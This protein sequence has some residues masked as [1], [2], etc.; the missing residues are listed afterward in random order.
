MTL[1]AVVVDDEPLARARLR[2]LLAQE[3]DLEVVGE[4]GNGADAVD[5]IGEQQPDVVFLDLHMPQSGG[6]EVAR[7]LRAEDVPAIVFVTAHDQ[8]AVEAFEVQA[9]DY[10]LKPVTRARLQEAVRR[11]RQRLRAPVRPRSGLA[12]AAA[13]PGEPPPPWLNRFAVKQG[14]QTLFVKAQDVDYIEAAANYVVLCTR[15]GNHILR[16]TL[17]NLEGSLSPASFLRVSRSVIVNLERVSAIRAVAPGEW[18]MV[19]AGGREFPMTRGW[20]EV[21]ERLQYSASP[22]TV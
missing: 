6:L 20:K 18:Q 3:P 17:R 14:N 2:R 11:V 12:P 9:T 7:A 16:E 5:C 8:H 10:L 13:A 1:R 21:Q 4:C 19:L 15:K 22:P